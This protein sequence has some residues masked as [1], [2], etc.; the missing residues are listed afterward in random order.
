MP[1]KLA[2]EIEDLF[3]KRDMLAAKSRLPKLVALCRKHHRLL[4]RTADFLLRLPDPAQAF[5]LL[6]DHDLDHEPRLLL[7]NAANFLG[8]SGYALRILET[9][10]EPV[11]V[12]RR[13]ET[14]QI[15]STTYHDVDALRYFSNLGTPQKPK[16]G[17]GEVGERAM[18]FR[19][20]ALLE[21]GQLEEVLAISNYF[22]QPHQP[23][24]RKAFA[25][26]F[27]AWAYLEL[28]EVKAASQHLTKFENLPGR[29]DMWP[30]ALYHQV[31]GM[32][33]LKRDNP[34]KATKHLARAW[35]MTFKPGLQPE[36]TWLP[37]LYLKGKARFADGGRLP[38]E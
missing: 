10:P 21:L 18:L 34:K 23:I 20:Y 17:L 8:A 9:V 4:A 5:R 31:A 26:I 29:G 30:H 7:A 36:A 16:P 24:G 22:L 33:A 37:V 25:L 6:C 1:D 35:K 32:M 13:I 2:D 27:T 12:K 28:D 14:G 15:L 38:D 11:K 3:L 19:C